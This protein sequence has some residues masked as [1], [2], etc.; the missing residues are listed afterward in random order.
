MRRQPDCTAPA[1]FLPQAGEL[2]PMFPRVA[3]LLVVSLLLSHVAAWS[4]AGEP[5]TW[6]RFDG[7]E[8]NRLSRERRISLDWG[9]ASEAVR[10]GET[11]TQAV[12]V[13]AA[14]D[15]N[16][17]ELWRIEGLKGNSSP[18]VFNDKLYLIHEEAGEQAA[19]ESSPRTEP[20]EQEPRRFIDCWYISERDPEAKFR[21]L[22]PPASASTPVPLLVGDATWR[23]LFCLLA[24]GEVLSLDSDLGSVLWRVSLPRILELEAAPDY[25]GTPLVFEHLLICAASWRT[26]E[27]QG[28]ACLVA[29]DR[30]NGQVCWI[31]TVSEAGLGG[32]LPAPVPCVAR[33]QVLVVSQIQ[34]GR[35]EF[36]QIRTGKPVAYM[37]LFHEQAYASELLFDR[38]RL[39]VLST[40]VEPGP[41]AATLDQEEQSPRDWETVVIDLDRELPMPT[42]DTAGGEL[43]SVHPSMRWSIPAS[44]HVTCLLQG[45]QIYAATA[46]KELLWATA[47][48]DREWKRLEM[49]SASRHH[50]NWVD[51][52]LLVVSASGYWE[53]FLTP[54]SPAGTAETQ[55][56]TPAAVRAI[57][58][59][60]WNEGLVC[61]PVLSK[62]RVYV[63]TETQLVCL[64]PIDTNSAVSDL[65][66]S[67]SDQ[68]GEEAEGTPGTICLIPSRQELSAGFQLP[69]QVQQYSDRGTFLRAMSAEEVSWS[70]DG[71]GV[72]DET[73]GILAAPAELSEA[74]S[75]TLQARWRNWT[76]TARVTMQPLPRQDRDATPLNDPPPPS[77]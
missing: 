70:W 28:T 13:L 47:G 50:M 22:L 59:E 75:G 25:M 11:G 68:A 3:C 58:A 66:P 56:G 72:L 8:H 69:W 41:D 73:T 37:P 65:I 52:Q 31:R 76:A 64:G 12:E 16:R 29:L 57:H 36:H 35:I 5:L 33:G 19:E 61:G 2:S 71:P 10:K 51:R 38:H 40:G 7:P 17:P 23:Q 30:R 6:P 26:G 4:G 54:S 45:D 15:S 24:S 53:V 34:A 27:N 44:R 63:R 74:V 43:P 77:R 9:N 49:H 32:Q 67:L 1:V 48:Q 62:Q 46:E 39:A 21:H 14:E 20:G 60:L 55:L 42:V 18:L